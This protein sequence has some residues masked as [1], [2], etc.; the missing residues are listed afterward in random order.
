MKII[1]YKYTKTS[2]Y[3]TIRNWKYLIAIILFFIHA[4]LFSE[5]I[6]SKY[7]GRDLGHT[8]KMNHFILNIIVGGITGGGFGYASSL[9][10]YDS[11]GSNGS[12]A[13]V[14]TGIGFLLGAAGGTFAT[15]WEM[16]KKEQFTYG[17][18]MWEYSWY[19]AI[20]GGLVGTGI[21]IIPYA[22]SNNGDDLLN[23]MGL[24]VL[25]GVPVSL[26]MFFIFYDD[27]PGSLGNLNPKKSKNALNYSFNYVP[28]QNGDQ[29]FQ[30]QIG[31][32]Y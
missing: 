2:Y 6:E 8:T 21:G 7:F 12:T 16:R 28:K 23:Y 5:D 26:V 24:G 30:F 9:V 20:L 11:K 13:G 29:Y 27:K 31:R 1:Q 22:D 17:K 4:N 32:N 19:G 14:F 10:A 25:I 18:E 3:H 15:F